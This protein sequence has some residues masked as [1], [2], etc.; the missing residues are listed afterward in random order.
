MTSSFYDSE[1]HISYPEAD[2]MVADYI[3]ERGPEKRRVTTKQI[4]RWR[5]VEDNHHN[6]LRVHGALEDVCDPLDRNWAGRTVF[7]L[8]RDSDQ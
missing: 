3:D 4:L 5:G 1:E 2:R 7:E 8:P 6:R